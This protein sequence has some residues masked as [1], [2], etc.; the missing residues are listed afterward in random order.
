MQNLIS[1]WKRGAKNRIVAQNKIN[2]LSSRSHS[3]FTI[4]L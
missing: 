4:T 3:I 2:D 1:E